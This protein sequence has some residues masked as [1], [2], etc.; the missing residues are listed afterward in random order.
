MTQIDGQAV[1][2]II[3]FGIAKTLGEA[4]TDKTLFTRFAEFLG[5]PL[6]MSPEQAEMSGQDVDTRTDVYSLGVVLYELLTGHTPFDRE[7]MKGTSYEGMRRIIREED[8][9]RPST[10]VSTLDAKQMSTVSQRRGNDARRLIESLRH[11]LDWIV[12]RALE[13][14]RNRRYE[15]AS[16]FADDV[17]RYLRNEPIV[18]CPPS[19]VYQFRKFV[20]RNQTAIVTSCL[21][22]L[23]LL[24]GIAV[25]GWQAYEASTARA[26]A[27]D[28][29]RE[30]DKQRRQAE[31]NLRDARQ[32][33]DRYF[34][35]VS[36][37][38]LLEEP[39]LLPLRLELIRNAAEFYDQLASREASDPETRFDLAMTHLRLGQIEYGLSQMHDSI[40]AL[41]KGFALIESLMQQW[42][43]HSKNYEKWL[44]FGMSLNRISSQSISPSDRS[45]KHRSSCSMELIYGRHWRDRI[46]TCL[47]SRVIFRSSMIFLK[48]K[49]VPWGSLRRRV[50]YWE[51]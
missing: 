26:T 6:Y 8:P 38:T 41:D 40:T 9:P 37:S 48:T 32:A 30:V 2:K 36:E 5:T 19:R 29:L 13:K 43:A 28:N 4:L 39:G 16:A 35:L 24:V 14:D 21:L 44:G 31:R 20:R 42:P 33:I 49:S 46:P 25:S 47:A 18:A 50:S 51:K 10:R 12:M 17:D 27:E 22:S 45:K 3:D 15:S 7:R 23:T 34:T 1:V 11:E